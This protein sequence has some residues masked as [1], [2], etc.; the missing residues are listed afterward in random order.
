MKEIGP[1]VRSYRPL[2]QSMTQIK[3]PIFE[4]TS[5]RPVLCMGDES[6]NC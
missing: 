4:R 3:L 1:G 6:I 5:S 2:Y